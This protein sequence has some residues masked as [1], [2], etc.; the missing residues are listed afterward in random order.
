MKLSD[1]QRHDLAVA[2][3]QM[4]VNHT[5]NA[6]GSEDFESTCDSLRNAYEKAYEYYKNQN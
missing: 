5:F 3:A 2:Y 4:F 6:Q 1:E